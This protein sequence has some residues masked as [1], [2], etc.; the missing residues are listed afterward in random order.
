MWYRSTLWLYMVVYSAILD[1]EAGFAMFLS[2]DPNRKRPC[3]ARRYNCSGL[4]HL[5]NFFADDF[6]VLMRH[7]ARIVIQGTTIDYFEIMTN[8]NFS[9]FRIKKRPCADALYTQ[10]CVDRFS[11][12]FR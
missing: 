2:G 6:F 5:F 9:G 3:T 10:Q 4:E 7:T 8:G 11:I 12:G 1:I